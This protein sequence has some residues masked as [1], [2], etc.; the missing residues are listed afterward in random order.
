MSLIPMLVMTPILFA[1]VFGGAQWTMRA[2]ERYR[3]IHRQR[4][5]SSSI[6]DGPIIMRDLFNVPSAVADGQ[7]NDLELRAARAELQRRRDTS[8]VIVVLIAGIEL[9]WSIADMLTRML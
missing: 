7:S 6:A 3:A 4:A 1:A 8:I 5:G 9:G 2:L